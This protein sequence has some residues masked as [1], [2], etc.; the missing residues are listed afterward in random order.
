MN[1]KEN[2]IIRRSKTDTDPVYMILNVSNNN[3]ITAVSNTANVTMEFANTSITGTSIENRNGGFSFSFS[4]VN[5][6]PMSSSTSFSVKVEEDSISYTI[7]KGTINF[8]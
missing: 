3:I 2:I 5:T 1:P 7:A 6:E 4:G 8:I